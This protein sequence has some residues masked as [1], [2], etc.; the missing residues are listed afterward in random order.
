MKANLISGVDEVVTSAAVA[1]AGFK[2][3]CAE[4]GPKLIWTF[5]NGSVAEISVEDLSDEIKYAAMMH[6]L[7]QTISDA[8]SGIK[9]AGES[10]TF[11][12]VRIDTLKGGEWSSRGKAGE[13]NN[14]LAQAVANISGKG[15]A[16][17]VA[18][19]GALDEAQRKVLAKKPQ[20][21]AEVA[22]LKAERLAKAVV[23]G[24][25]SLSDL[26]GGKL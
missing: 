4:V 15:I 1:K 24:V 3:K 19:I 20:V 17:V 21:A 25:D 8:Y 18:L 16:D 2:A 6:G 7:K 26:F 13:G 22:K 10:Y 14:D 23:E 9:T 11:A 5:G 12:Q